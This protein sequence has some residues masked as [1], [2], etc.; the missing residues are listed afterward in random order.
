TVLPICTTSDVPVTTNSALAVCTTT[1][2][3]ICTTS[4]VPVT[5]ASALAVCT[6]TVL[7]VCTTAIIPVSTILA[8]TDDS[9]TATNIGF[10]GGGYEK[11]VI[12]LGQWTYSVVNTSDA[13][14]SAKAYLEIS[15]DSIHW[16]TD[17]SVATIEPSGLET[18]V[19][20]IFL[21]YARLY[22]YALGT[23][24]TVTL[25]LF[26]QGNSGGDIQP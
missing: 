21:K 9:T 25:N 23:S 14:G 22:Y 15:P 4:S 16:K 11:N 20:S 19:P 3:P 26:F 10:G 18:F 2:L 17:G 12:A 1:V 7:P 6:T 13:G 24:P 8:V 5:A